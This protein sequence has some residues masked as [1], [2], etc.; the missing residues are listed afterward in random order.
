[1]GIT[2]VKLSLKWL[3][4]AVVPRNRMN[5]IIWKFAAKTSESLEI[6]S[7]A[8]VDSVLCAKQTMDQGCFY[9]IWWKKKQVLEDFDD[10]LCPFFQPVV[11]LVTLSGNIFEYV[12]NRVMIHKIQSFDACNFFFLIGLVVPLFLGQLHNISKH[13]EHVHLMKDLLSLSSYFSV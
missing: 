1:M 9:E 6:Y 3:I 5:Q 2:P 13:V 12:S 11:W 7:P 10:P 4:R 8:N